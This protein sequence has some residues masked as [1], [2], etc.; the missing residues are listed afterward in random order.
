M[1]YN[2]IIYEILEDGVACITLNRPESLNALTIDMLLEVYDAAWTIVSDNYFDRDF[3]GL[4]W[5]AVHERYRPI[6][7]STDNSVVLYQEAIR[8]ML[9]ALHTSHLS[10]RLPKDAVSEVNR[11]PV[12]CMP[13]PESPANRM[14][15]CSSR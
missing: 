14:T 5:E 12:N 13:S 2:S 8:P 1:S 7:E 4:D 10:A 6:A 11:S 3:G 9:A 15:T